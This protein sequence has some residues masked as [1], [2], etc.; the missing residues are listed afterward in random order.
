M[1]ALHKFYMAI[2][3]GLLAL[4]AQAADQWLYVEQDNGLITNV[5]ATEKHELLGS[6]NEL[7]QSLS[8]EKEQLSNAVQ[9]KKF[10]TKDAVITAVVPG[11][12]LYASYR[13]ASYKSA[14]TDLAKVSSRIEELNTDAAWLA[15]IEGDTKVAMLY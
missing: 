11:G 15:G 2:P 14:K 12:M 5:P 7:K 4:N 10:S 1:K 13:M 8:S 3:L 9:E 6:V